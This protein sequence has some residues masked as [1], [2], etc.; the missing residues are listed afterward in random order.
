DRSGTPAQWNQSAYV[1]ASH[2]DRAESFGSAVAL[3]QDTLVAG[4]F[5]EGVFSESFG[6]PEAGAAY[7]F[8]RAGSRGPKIA[9]EQLE[10]ATLSSGISRVDWGNQAVGG[11]IFDADRGFVIKNIG[12]S[13]LAGLEIS[14]DGPNA[15]DF[16]AS[17]ISQR[18]SPGE[19]TNLYLL[20]TPTAPGSSGHATVMKSASYRCWP[21][22]SCDSRPWRRQR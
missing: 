13:D 8:A 5:Y 11:N 19:S 16:L 20:M 4:A 17:P 10:G 3:S 9:V 6:Y 15:S 14:L 12:G 1:K 22:V 7:V 21:D 18:L 2:S